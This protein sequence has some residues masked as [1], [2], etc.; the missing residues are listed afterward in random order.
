MG[1]SMGC[2]RPQR[3]ELGGAPPL[4]QKKRLRF[5]RK[6]KGRRGRK[7]EADRQESGLPGSRDR[8]PRY[9]EQE[10]EYEGEKAT[11]L[12]TTDSN[13][14]LCFRE[15]PEPRSTHFKASSNTLTPGCQSVSMGGS[16]LLV[17]TPK[18]S[19]A[20][21]GVFC[22][23]GQE[24]TVSA[25]VEVCSLPGQT[26][27]GKTPPAFLALG[28]TTT[29]TTKTPSTSS[30]LGSTTPGGGRVCRVREKVQG[31]LEKP[32]ILRPK[33]EKKEKGRAREK[34][35]QQQLPQKQEVK[36]AGGMNEGRPGGLGSGVQATSERERKGVIHIREADGKLCVVRTVYP[37]DYGSP[38]WRGEGEAGRGVEVRSEPPIPSPVTGNVLTVQLSEDD[39]GRAKMTDPDPWHA[40]SLRPTRNRETAAATRQFELDTPPGRQGA[41]SLLE[42]G[43]ASDLPATSPG[44][45]GTTPSQT[46]WGGLTTSSSSERL[47]S[48]A[49]SPLSPLQQAPVKHLPQ[50]SEIY[51]SGE[52]G[53]LTAKEKLLLWTKQATEGYPGLRCSNFTS[54]WSSGRLFNALLPDLVDMEV[55]THQSNRDNLEQAFEIAESLGVTRLLD[56]EDVDVPAPDEKSVITYV[57]SIYDA[58]PKIP[59]GGEGISSHE[60][61]QRWSEYQARFSSLMQWS[62]QHTA[63]MADKNFPQNPALYNQYI[64]FKETEIPVKEMEKSRVEHLYKLLEMW[65][66]FGRI[67]LPQGVHPNEMEEEWGKLILE[68]LDREKALRPA[69]DRVELLL[70]MANKIQNTALDCEEKLTLAKNTLQADLSRMERREGVLCEGELACYLQDCEALI[71]Q[72]NQDVGVLREERYYQVDQLASRVSGLQEELVSL[73]LQ[74]ASVYRKGHFSSQSPGEQ[75]AP[76]PA[77]GGHSLGQTLLGAVGA[78]GAA[79]AALLRQPMA[80]SQLVA[81]SS[82]EDEGSLRFIYELLGWVEETQDLLE[83]AEWGADLPSVENNLHEHNEIHTAGKVSPNFKNS[84]CETMAKLE[85]QYC[86]LLERSSWRLRS[87]E[88]LHGFVTRCTEE[89]IWLN[90]REEEEMAYDW[91]HGN[92]SLGPKRELYVE[93]RSELDEKQDMMRVLQET[94]DRLC[95]ENH[96]AKQTVEAYSAA[97]QTQWQWVRQLCVCVEQH[98]KDNTAYFQFMGEVRDC[99]SYLRQLQDTIKRQYTCDRNSRLSKLEDLLQDSMEEKE[100]LIGYRKSVASLV[101]RAKAVV[102]LRPR[103]ADSPLGAAT[104]IRAICD[105]RQIEIT[106]SRGEECVLEDNSQRTK[107]KVISPSGNE[108]MV[109]SV[110]FTVPPPNQEAIDTASRYP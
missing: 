15:A 45:A 9:E 5:M 63:L 109:P 66:E 90:E 78:V 74:C 53:D 41:A 32:W 93:M 105:Y 67:K 87:L 92:T 107:W 4:S 40:V 13:T 12:E 65:I 11:L 49:E 28:G 30:S 59:E 36:M 57:A 8:D 106:I 97:L 18:P 101:G 25:I 84:Y 22:L 31:V 88:S 89:L 77:V 73:R 91:G 16:S 26:P 86:K 75:T 52:S 96:P 62:R 71:R 24:D 23:P 39:D 60:V 17:V 46:D 72:L 47:D 81:M 54:S 35:Q 1:S 42:S 103:S 100:Q 3:E 21:R 55:V 7:G 110:C 79:G 29:T 61:D 20:W 83:G 82:S 33:K 37:S 102:Q 34:Q 98:L 76:R 108:A 80:R 58:F 70:Q 44:T 64:H 94:A 99:E 2:V 95:Q 85:H 50:I 43:Y 14:R 10:E 69:V 19:P 38:V 68:M 6:R 56:A 27:T 48:A 51:V 104:P